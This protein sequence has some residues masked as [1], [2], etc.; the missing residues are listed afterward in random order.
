[1]TYEKF[2]VKVEQDTGLS[3]KEIFKTARRLI[4]EVLSIAFAI[5]YLIS[6][7]FEFSSWMVIIAI[8]LIL[9]FSSFSLASDSGEAFQKAIKIGK[10][11]PLFIILAVVSFFAIKLLV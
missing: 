2:A 4:I 8:F 6:S 10:F 5:G 9:L 7:V 11:Y 1:M 3:R